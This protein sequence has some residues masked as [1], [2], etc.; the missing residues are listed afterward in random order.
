MEL[1]S[2]LHILVVFALVSTLWPIARILDRAGLNRAWCLLAIF[3]LVNWISLWVLAYV[4]WPALGT[5]R[6]GS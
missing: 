6:A 5:R 3:P 2:P 1:L 4:N